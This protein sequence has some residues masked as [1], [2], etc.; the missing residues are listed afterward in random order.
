[1]HDGGRAAPAWS[2]L[3]AAHVDL[4]P[5]AGDGPAVAVGE[6]C[7]EP[8]EHLVAAVGLL[9]DPIDLLGSGLERAVDGAATGRDELDLA[10]GVPHRVGASELLHDE[11]H[12]PRIRHGE[13][14]SAE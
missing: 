3:L 6:F 7:G 5:D 2:A 14:G 12:P 1:M 13:Q 9:A 11:E 4:L 10:R 8:G